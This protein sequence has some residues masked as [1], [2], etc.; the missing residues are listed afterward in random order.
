[1]IEVGQMS[2]DLGKV[3][4]SMESGRWD[5]AIS[6]LRP[7]VERRPFD[8]RAIGKL[9]YALWKSGERQEGA[10]TLERAL[11][12]DPDDGEVIKDCVQVFWEAGRREDALQVLESY[13]QRNPW[14]GD[15][16]EYMDRLQSAEIG[17]ARPCQPNDSGASAAALLVGLGEEEF[18]K[19]NMERAR[20]CFEMALEKDPGNA[21]AHNNLGVLAWQE[22]DLNAAL[23]CFDRAL[24]LAPTDGEI[25]CN[26]ARALG[27]AGH[28]ETASQ[29]LEIYLSAHPDDT[30]VWGEYRELVRQGAQSWKPDHLDSG[31]A[32]VYVE[33][34]R[35]LAEAGDLQGAAEAL[36]R[37]VRVD[38]ENVEGYQQLAL[39]HMGLN[40]MQD[41]LA[42]LEQAQALDE[43]NQEVAEALADVRQRLRETPEEDEEPCAVCSGGGLGG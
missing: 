23:A 11:Q 21:K 9:G 35:R 2:A 29:L 27:A 22:G 1:M 7:M 13:L 10:E 15:V 8:T 28:C 32:A 5:E 6:L 19:G 16:K 25:L 43:D 38:P 3:L 39:L 31:V 37:A 4:H 12:L 14:D 18:E 34:G 24:D 36:A 40:Q 20:T 33:M 30:D 41:A 17:E 42:L 26:A